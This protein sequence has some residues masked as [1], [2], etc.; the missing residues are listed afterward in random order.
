VSYF[1]SRA[2]A[3]A[4][5]E[6]E[7]HLINVHQN[8]IART[9]VRQHQLDVNRN[10]LFRLRYSIPPKPIPDVHCVLNIRNTERSRHDNRAEKSVTPL[11]NDRSKIARVRTLQD[12]LCIKFSALVKQEIALWL[13]SEFYPV[14]T[15]SQQRNNQ[16]RLM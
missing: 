12:I 11:D 14:E 5:V 9:S 10:R 3:A 6:K 8:N 15:D 13:A 7:W 16:G 1:I 4:I 2:N